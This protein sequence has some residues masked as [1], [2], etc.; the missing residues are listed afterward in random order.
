MSLT[1]PLIEL[2]QKGVEVGIGKHFDHTSLLDGVFTTLVTLGV[3]EARIRPRF[4]EHLA[5]RRRAEGASPGLYLVGPNADACA[6]VAAA[7]RASGKRR[8][9]RMMAT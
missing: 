7:P 1:A 2:E 6:G 4:R 5:L 8:G 3:K 9:R